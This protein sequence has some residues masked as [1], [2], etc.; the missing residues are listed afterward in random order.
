MNRF[1]ELREAH[2]Y[3]QDYVAEAIGVSRI[4]YVRYENSDRQMKVSELINLAKLYHVSI[5][6][7]LGLTDV[8]VWDKKIDPFLLSSERASDDSVASDVI[9]PELQKQIERYIDT[10]VRRALDKR[11]L[12][13]D[14]PEAP[15]D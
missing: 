15:S 10:A 11:G 8:A 2:G 3:T 1:R 4:T 12:S 7:L 13:S 6:Y 14:D 5:D 9:T